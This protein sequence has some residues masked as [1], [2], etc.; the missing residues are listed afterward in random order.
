MVVSLYD[1]ATNQKSAK[2]VRLTNEPEIVI[3]E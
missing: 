2:T 1:L 3:F